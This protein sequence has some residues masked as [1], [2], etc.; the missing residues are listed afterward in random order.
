MV[1]CSLP[2]IVVIVIAALV[3][4]DGTQGDSSDGD[5]FHDDN[6][7]DGDYDCDD[8]LGYFWPRVQILKMSNQSIK[9]LNK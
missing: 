4:D 2:S 6:D 7:Y 8:K 3:V 9:M 1:G 5:H